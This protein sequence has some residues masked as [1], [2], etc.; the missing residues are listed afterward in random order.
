MGG[1]GAGAGT[2]AGNAEKDTPPQADE[3]GRAGTMAGGPHCRGPIR[4][5][6]NSRYFIVFARRVSQI[7]HSSH[8]FV[9]RDQGL[10]DSRWQRNSS[11]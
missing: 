9:G 6:M 5:I 4:P 1:E 2:G 11:P 10:H 7:W 3:W 8:N